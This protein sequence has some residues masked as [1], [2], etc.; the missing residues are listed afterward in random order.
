MPAMDELQSDF[1]KPNELPSTS[2][3]LGGRPVSESDSVIAAKLLACVKPID[4]IARLL[5]PGE[6]SPRL[7][8]IASILSMATIAF[9]NLLTPPEIRLPILYLFP[10]AAIA[11]HCERLGTTLVSLALSVA[12]QLWNYSHLS[13]LYSTPVPDGMLI[14][15]AASMLTVALARA[16]RANFLA[17]MSL[18]ATDCLTGLYNRRSFE[19]AADNEILR[20]RRYG[21]VFSIAVIDLDGF[22][23]LNDSKG[24]HSGDLALKLVADV[25]RE[26]TRVTD[27]V[28]RLGG[29]EFAVLMPNTPSPACVSLSQKLAVIIASRMA[30]AGFCVTAS[31]GCTSFEEAPESTLIALQRADRAMY[32]AKVGG[33]DRAV[34]L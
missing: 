18:A 24:H 32:A 33:K 29:D 31:I 6:L 22:K 26:Q 3:R 4:L 11:L 5:T 19:V 2:T 13:S 27:L 10:L 15:G 7:V 21:G 14:T 23:K 20:Q 8:L 12:F 30:F 1:F 25:L 17:T 34:A 16:T 9:F 28:A